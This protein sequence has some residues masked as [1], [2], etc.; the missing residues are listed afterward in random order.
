MFDRHSLAQL[1]FLL[2]LLIPGAALAGYDADI[3]G[4]TYTGTAQDGSTIHLNVNTRN[5]ST[6]DSGYGGAATFC[7][8]CNIDPP[9]LWNDF[10]QQVKKSFAYNQTI[11]VAMPSFTLDDDGSWDI[12]CVVL[13]S[14]CDSDFDT[15][16]GSLSISAAT[17]SSLGYPLGGCGITSSDGECENN[18]G[19]VWE[20]L[21]AGPLDCWHK[22]ETCSG[23]KVC[24]DTI[25]G[26]AGCIDD[27]HEDYCDAK[28]NAGSACA[29]GQ[30]DCDSDGECMGNLKCMGPVL[31]F[32]GLDGCCTDGD[33][34]D[35]TD[36]VPKNC[37]ALGYPLGECGITSSDGEC[38]ANFTEVWECVDAGVMDCWQKREACDGT[39]V[40][41]DTTLGAASCIDD[42]HE[43]YCDAKETA[44]SACAWGQSDCDTDGEC[45]GSLECT[46]PVFP[47]SGLDGCCFADE[48]WDGSTCDSGD[49]DPVCGDNVCDAGETCA[50]CPEDCSPCCGDGLC[51]AGED[52]SICEDDCGPC[53]VPCGDG[54]CD[55]GAGEDCS[56]CEDDCGPC[57][58]P[59]GDGICDAGAGEDCASC[60]DDCGPCGVPCGDG[61]CDAGAGETCKN[62]PAD[63]GGCCGDGSCLAAHGEDCENCEEDCGPCTQLCGNG[64]CDVLAGETCATCPADCAC[65]GDCGD[66]VCLAPD[67]CANCFADCGACCGDGSCDEIYG[68]DATSC[69]ADCE[70]D[71]SNAACGDGFCDDGPEAVC[72]S[73]S[74]CEADCGAC[75]GDGLCDYKTG[76]DCSACAAD[77][78][79]CPAGC[80]DEICQPGETCANC[81]ADCG[82]CCG[83]D[84]CEPSYGEDS[85]SC[86]EDCGGVAPSC[87]DGACDGFESCFTCAPDCGTCC[88]NSICEGV[89]GED[90]GSCT[91]DC[92]TCLGS[93]G[94]GACTGDEDCFKCPSDCGDCC[95][96]GVCFSLY[97]EDCAWC[98]SDCGVCEELCGDGECGALEDCASCA[99]DCGAC[100]GD[101][102]CRVE[103]GE[104]CGTCA[105]D[106]PVCPAPCG[107]GNCDE[108][109]GETCLSCEA[110]CGAC[111]PGCGDQVCDDGAGEDCLSC[112]A[113]CGECPCVPS[114]AGK[115]CGDDGCEGTCG[116][117]AGAASCV[118]GACVAD[119]VEDDVEVITPDAD[120]PD[121]GD[122]DVEPSDSAKPEGGDWAWS[123]DEEDEGE[124]S[125]SGGCALGGRSPLGALSLLLLLA[126]CAP[127]VARR[128]PGTR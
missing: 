102:S 3:T 71:C 87:G 26:A 55:A 10:D 39:K 45:M 34:W 67:S 76:E 97:G 83:N 52:C 60:E 125:S 19:E 110:D 88:G 20:C 43:D 44:G 27:G 1:V 48:E 77:C 31:P 46:G 89:Y 128:R 40:C 58:D 30:S 38:E 121:S 32:T 69:S 62:C 79:D 25:L 75:C 68:E 17:C 9:G 115:D 122:K 18:F 53:V 120:A 126:L 86:S 85:T 94:D 84:A 124:V 36:C 41:Q 82:E 101:G 106:C 99:D 35:G 72:E 93:C 11:S 23:S 98:P 6:T 107:D 116:D 5:L 112:A 105:A 66:G 12:E 108:A 33:D 78:G 111:T 65:A 49:V 113:D 56:S 51:G 80:G 42:G 37:V 29:E 95:G 54:I 24:Q 118:D 119:P 92:G 70:T 96:D 2:G 14:S 127:L 15:W 109:A 59:C 4:V 104:D 81:K 74:D 16:S 123:V 91:T 117:C 73:C 7:I 13:D 57:V 103:Q 28:E 21:D 50:G 90:C 61:S 114:C 63:C 8:Q 64:S 47:I 22:R 100:C